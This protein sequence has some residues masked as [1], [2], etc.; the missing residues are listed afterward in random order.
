MFITFEGIEGSGKSTQATLLK[1]YLEEIGYNVSLTREPGWGKIG[2][3]TREL[4]LKEKNNNITAFTELCLFCADRAQHVKE[5]IK[6]SLES[7][8]IVISDRYKDSTVVYQGYG[9]NL[10]L[11]LVR[12]MAEAST[13]GVRPNL[14]L[15]LDLPAEEGLFRLQLR[16]T[17]T[18]IDKEPLEFHKRIRKGYLI[19][20]NLDP[21]RIKIIDAKNDE[22][23]VHEKIKEVV[24][25]YLTSQKKKS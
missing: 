6:P 25:L 23:S 10:D 4:L 19:E 7:G 8:N 21:A 18:R 24:N 9:R 20:A 13:E 12:E 3:F 1:R 11:H 5:F 22:I 15:L 16:K 2:R 17:I 14:T